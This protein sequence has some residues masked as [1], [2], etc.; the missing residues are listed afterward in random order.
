MIKQKCCPECGEKLIE[1]ELENEGLVPYCKSCKEYRFPMY[2]VAVSMITVDIN[3]NK[4]LLIQQ[5]QKK[6]NIL[7]AGYV[8]LGEG[9]EDAVKRELSEEVNLVPIKV[10][11]NTSKY[12]PNSNTLMCNFIA[13]IKDIEFLKINREVDT[14]NWYTKSDA[15]EN[16]KPESLAKYFYLE[17]LKKYPD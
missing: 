16:I 4:I 6:F 17:F 3:T 2:N 7:V 1:L 9:L 13:Y 12:Y 5:Y 15:L 10:E 11:F 8:N 14:Y